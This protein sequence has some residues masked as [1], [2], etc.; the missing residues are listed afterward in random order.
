M[1]KMY[2]SHQIHKNSTIGSKANELSSQPQLIFLGKHTPVYMY[3]ALRRTHSRSRDCSC[4]FVNTLVHV[5]MHICVQ[6]PTYT[7]TWME[8]CTNVNINLRNLIYL[9]QEK[10]D[11]YTVES[12]SQKRKTQK[13]KMKILLIERIWEGWKISRKTSNSSGLVVGRARCVCIHISY[14]N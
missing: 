1:Y 4:V 3:I 10:S 13:H 7:H 14:F 2:V 9:T 5:Q 12:G 8:M 6:R 11:N